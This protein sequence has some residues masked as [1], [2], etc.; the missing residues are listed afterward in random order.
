MK[1]RQK[2]AADLSDK[3]SSHERHGDRSIFSRVSGPSSVVTTQPKMARGYNN[4][5]RGWCFLT[6]GVHTDDIAWE[7]Q[8]PLANDPLRVQWRNKRHDIPS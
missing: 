1:S 5:F 6:S 8:Y 4:V 2:G 7:T 3:P